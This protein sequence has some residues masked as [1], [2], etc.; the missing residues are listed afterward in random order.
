[1]D[2]GFCASYNLNLKRL[3]ASEVHKNMVATL[4]NGVAEFKMK[5]PI[6]CY[7]DSGD[8]VMAAVV[9]VF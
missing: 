2:I 8:N 4:G 1:M 7:F 9:H 3:S 5:A 6:G